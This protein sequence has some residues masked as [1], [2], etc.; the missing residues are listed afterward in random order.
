M[1]LLLLGKDGQ[2]GWELQRSLSPLGNVL[3]L[4]RSQCDLSD[5]GKLKEIIRKFNPQVIVNAAAY[6]A[7]D[8]AEADLELAYTIN[9]SLPALLAA[10]ASTSGAWLVHYS[11]D[12]VFDGSKADAYVEDDTPHPLNV[13][14]KSKLAGEQQIMLSGCKHLILRTS[15]VFSAHGANFAKTMLR[16]AA[17]RSELKVVGDQYGAPT[18]AELIADVT[19]LCLVRLLL[20]DDCALQGIYHLTASGYTSW[21]GYA[22]YVIEQ[23]MQGGHALKCL[24]AA[25]VSIP[26]SD[27]PVPAKRPYNSR[28]NSSKLQQIF[29][30]SMPPW[31][32][33]V[34]R[35]LGELSLA[36]AQ[37]GKS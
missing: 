21:H 20:K 23:A 13:Y 35:M 34:Q 36:T 5:L 17:E 19:A 29:G 11:T 28:L 30:L 24:P 3:A 22:Q 1:K 7:V 31:Q 12:Y 4:G 25:V 32:L 33:H 37:Q 2:V 18:S 9:R 15:W 16:L 10:E 6:T 27:Y 8:K 26:A 14:G